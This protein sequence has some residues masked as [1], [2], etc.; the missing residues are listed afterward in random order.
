MHIWNLKNKMT[1]DAEEVQNLWVLK[2]SEKDQHLKTPK[3]R[4][5]EIPF[6]KLSETYRLEIASRPEVD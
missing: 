2:N 5:L 6:S 3:Y 1:D 4:I